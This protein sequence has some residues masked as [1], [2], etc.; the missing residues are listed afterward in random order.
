MAVLRRRCAAS[1]AALLCAAGLLR[2]GPALAAPTAHQVEAVFL[3]YFTQFVDWPPGAFSAGDS[4]IVIGVLGDD[5]FGGALDQA[6]AG[7]RVN[8]RRVIVRRL[9]RV[10]DAMGCQI[11]Y[12]SA[13]E[14]PQLPRILSALEGH[15]V[16]T[17]SSLD[18]F[19]RRGGMIRFV[20]VHQHVRLRIN[21]R[22]AR[23]AGLR[24]SSKLLSAAA[25]AAPGEG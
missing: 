8:G 16:L 14:A 4:P 7:E 1:A 25:P 23:D 10:A 17:V 24:L 20:L 11:V 15:G 19:A 3:F 22:A 6:V 18:H 5:P 9:Q 21:A 2:A 12:I 13:S